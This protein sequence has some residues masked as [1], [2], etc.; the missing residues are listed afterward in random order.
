MYLPAALIT[1]SMVTISTHDAGRA[2]RTDAVALVSARP[3]R[4]QRDMHAL[5]VLS[6]AA[7]AGEPLEAS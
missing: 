1:P 3:A 7:H 6:I 4:Y 5:R 2:M